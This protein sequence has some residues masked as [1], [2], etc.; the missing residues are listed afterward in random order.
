MCRPRHST[1][2]A[3]PHR[4][5]PRPGLGGGGHAEQLADAIEERYRANVLDV[6]SLGGLTDERTRD[7]V[8]N[9]LLPELRRRKL[10]D[11][12]YLGGTY[13][14]NLELPAPTG[15]TRA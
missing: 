2:R 1:R 9:G 7:F 6:I 11:I 3:R 14:A 10:L 15:P 12:D 4:Q 5:R 13:R 8:V